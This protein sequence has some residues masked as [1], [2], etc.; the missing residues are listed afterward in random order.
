GIDLSRALDNQTMSEIVQALHDHLVIFFRDQR[1]TPE[2]HIAFSRRFGAL[3]VHDF[4]AHMPGHPEI[5]EVL[6]EPQERGFNFGGVWHSDVTYQ[7]HPALGSVL[8]AHEIPK[9]GGDTMFANQ[10]LAFETLSPGL[11]QMLLGLKAV[12]SPSATYSE[13]AIRTKG[14]REKRAI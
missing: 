10:Y 9:V 14:G 8:Y 6:K 4:V 3:D 11:Q 7:E 12:H 1:L 5:I 2:Q 13:E